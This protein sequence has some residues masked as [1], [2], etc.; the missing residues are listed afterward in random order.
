M[1]MESWVQFC[2]WQNVSGTSKQN[3][4]AEEA[5]DF[6]NNQKVALYSM[7]DLIQVQISQIDLKRCYSHHQLVVELLAAEAA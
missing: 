1:P 2:S 4:I 3:S 5:K 7:S 6:F